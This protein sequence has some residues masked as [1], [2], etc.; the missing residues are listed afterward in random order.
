MGLCEAATLETTG[1]RGA[2]SVTSD[3]TWVREVKAR[4]W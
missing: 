2:R 1:R 3:S 4:H